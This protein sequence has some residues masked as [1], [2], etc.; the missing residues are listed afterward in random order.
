MSFESQRLTINLVLQTCGYLVIAYLL[1][2]TRLF[3][4]FMH[5][6][7]RLPHR[8][9]CYVVFS[10]FCIMGTYLGLDID[11]AI[12]NTRAIGAVLGGTLGGPA[13]GLAVGLTGG[14]HRYMLGGSTAFA[15]MVSTVI[16]GLMGGMYHLWMIRRDRLE[17]LFRPITVAAVTFVAEV[18][19]MAL[20]MMLVRPTAVASRLVEHIATPMLVSNTV[21]A[22]L[23][24]SILLDR[25]RTLEQQSSTFSAKALTIAARAEGA[26]RGGLDREAAERVARIMYE[27]TGV[28]AVAITD[29]EKMLAFI[30]LG[31]DHH[32]ALRPIT[33]LQT[34]QAIE[35][36]IVIYADGNEVDYQ[37]SISAN[38]PLG[39]ALVIPLVG[40]D[41]KVIGTIKLYEP[42]TKLFS[43]INRTLGEGIAR[44]LSAQILTGRYEEQTRLLTRSELKLLQAQVNPHFLF[45]ALNTVAAVI[46]TDPDRARELVCDLSTFF[47]KNLKRPSE[48]V[49]LED[50]LDHVRSYLKIEEARFA[51]RLT[52]RIDVAPEF[53]HVRLPAFSVQPIV[54]NAIKHGT[55]QLVVPGEVAISAERHGEDVILSVI[56]NAGLFSDATSTEGLGTHLV[57]RRLQS[58]FGSTYGMRVMCEPN[59]FT[60]VMLRLPMEASS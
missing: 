26:L 3:L 11:D 25:R 44:L 9:A 4:P 24:M 60:K 39:A 36:N 33:S 15:C 42:K 12:A 16:E 7:V 32:V 29:C 28:G 57:S 14:W 56:D 2:R 43:T 1:S 17:S 54:E 47:R 18:V 46:G 30:G 52:V 41:D 35:Q 59:E 55:S 19:Q 20:L 38:C 34:L 40:A 50:E 51:G 48:V 10:L 21:G 31:D 27:E 22:G 45:N 53:S 6:T 8:V 49:T 13:V 37:C 23:F 58:H 5:V